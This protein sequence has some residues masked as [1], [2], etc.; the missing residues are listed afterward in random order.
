[1]EDNLAPQDFASFIMTTHANGRVHQIETLDESL[2]HAR[3]DQSPLDVIEIFG[4]AARCST[5][6][7]RRG[8]RAGDNFDILCSCDLNDESNQAK[9]IKYIKDSRPLVTIMAPA[10]TPYGPMDNTVKH[11]SWES[12]KRSLDYARPHGKFCGR[13][14]LL[15]DKLN[16]FFIVEQPHSSK[17]WEKSEWQEVL[18]SPTTVSLVMRQCMTGQKGP[19]GGPAKKPTRFIANHRKML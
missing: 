16:L 3:N 15:V 17:L 7:I 19:E 18:E 9:V 2:Y 6:A 4:G 13:V 14:A 5:M 11:V 12:W 1:M 10:C 8:L